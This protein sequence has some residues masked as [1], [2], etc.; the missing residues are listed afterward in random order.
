MK[1]L[2][3]RI[4]GKYKLEDYVENDNEANQCKTVQ[5]KPNNHGK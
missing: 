5:L 2:S 1:K 3:S 4:G